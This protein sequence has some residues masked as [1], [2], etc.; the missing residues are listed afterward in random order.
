MFFQIY[1]G[2]DSAKN[3]RPFYDI[4]KNKGI[5]IIEDITNSIYF[6][7]NTSCPATY[8]IGSLRKW[9][10]IID[11]GI[12]V[13]TK[14]IHHIPIIENSIFIRFKKAAM[15]K[16]LEYIENGNINLKD[17][18]FKIN[19]RAENYL[20]NV[21]KCFAMSFESKKILSYID[22]SEINKI[23]INNYLFLYKELKNCKFIEPFTYDKNC[24]PS[25]YFTFYVDSNIKNELK[26]ILLRNRISIIELWPIH[27]RVL[28]ELDEETKSMYNEVMALS[29]DQRYDLEDMKKIVQTINLLNDK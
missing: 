29:C 14:E 5:I 11:G 22:I 1:F 13:S 12:L 2:V 23:R 15:K 6:S 26:D 18:I 16:K 19:S 10:P 21:N 25:L 3:V 24:L 9:Y 7:L 4:Y 20:D 17:Q 8:Y 28:K 27:N